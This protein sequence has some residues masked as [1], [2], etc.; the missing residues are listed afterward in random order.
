MWDVDAKVIAI[1]KTKVG[2]PMYY[3]VLR[4]GTYIGQTYASLAVKAKVG[5]VIRVNVDHIT[6]RPDG[7]INWYS[8]KPKNIKEGKV[9][10]GKGLTQIG[11]GG[12]DTLDLAKE[13]YL[14]S[15]GTDLKWKL[16]LPLHKKYK[17]EV[18]PKKIAKL[19]GQKESVPTGKA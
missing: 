18:M 14:A 11:I 13:I 4:D 9:T 10:V 2:I 6:I 16:W 19:K 1:E 8:P 12:P 7:S 17:E 3:C 15:G 5:D